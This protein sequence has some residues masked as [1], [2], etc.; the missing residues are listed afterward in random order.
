MKLPKHFLSI[1]GTIMFVAAM[2][3]NF[4]VPQSD[5]ILL[6]QVLIPAMTTGAGVVSTY[7]PVPSMENVVIIGDIDTTCPI[8][9]VKLIVDGKTKIDIFNSQPICQAFMKMGQKLSGTVVGLCL[10]LGTGRING[11][12]NTTLQ[13]TNDGATTPVVS[14]SSDSGNG[15]SFLTSQTSINPNANQ[16]FEGFDLLFMTDPANVS[17]VDVVMADGTP[18]NMTVLELDAWYALGNDSEANGRLATLVTTIDNRD[19]KFKSVKLNVGATAVVVV[20]VNVEA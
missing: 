19:G 17:S 7:G 11:T 18:N 4:F 15:K 13:L 12:Q 14:G 10:K 9:S 16:T 20:T 6:A 1:V 8:R 2:V 5:A 3:Y